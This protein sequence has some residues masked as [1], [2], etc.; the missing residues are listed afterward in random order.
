M[1]VNLRIRTTIFQ[2][3]AGL[4]VGEVNVVQIRA[5]TSTN[6]TPTTADTFPFE[7]TRIE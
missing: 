7:W 4:F 6:E 1:F 2:S 5:D 3:D